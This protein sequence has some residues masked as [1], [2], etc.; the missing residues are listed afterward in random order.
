MLLE[1]FQ[2]HKNQQAV[3]SMEA[4]PIVSNKWS[5][6]G[7]ACPLCFGKKDSAFQD[8]VVQASWRNH[9]TL[10]RWLDFS[11]VER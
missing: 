4:A 6:I 1:I 5:A 3:L 11:Q 8:G 9:V 2:A 7:F 10:L